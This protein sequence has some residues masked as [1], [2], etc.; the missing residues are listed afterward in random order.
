ML[1]TTQLVADAFTERLVNAY[2][3]TFSTWRP[4]FK[5]VIS[6]VGRMAI[7]RI[8]DSDALYHNVE[9][10]VMVTLVGQE[11]LRGKHIREGGVTPSDW[12]HFLLALLTHDIGYVRGVCRGDTWESYIVNEA[13]ERVTLDPGASDASLTPFHVD[14]GKM[15]VKERFAGT[16]IIDV[17]R[18]VESLELTRFPVPDDTDHQDTKS[19]AGLVRAADLIGQLADP[20]YMRK[21]NALYHEFEETGTNAKL[22]Y[23]TPADLAEN[24][25]KFYWH[26]VRPYVADAFRYLEV[27]QEGK[28]W[29]ANLYAHVFAAEHNEHQLGPQPNR[30]RERAAE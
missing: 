13:G 11:I 17:E 20:N 7:E 14:R 4:E 8:A 22:G 16:S 24:Y 9:H 25:P 5:G 15:F 2:D 30:V 19:H 21:I 3:N 6:W 28:Q 27:T 29:I 1:N 23:K 10:T 12:V 26:A 18:V